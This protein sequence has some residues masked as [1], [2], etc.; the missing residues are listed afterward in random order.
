MIKIRLS[1]ITWTATFL[2]VISGMSLSDAALAGLITFGSNTNQFTMEFVTIGNPGNADDTTGAPNPAGSVAY[3]YQMGKFEVSENMITKYNANFGTANNLIITKDTR[4]VN[5][6]ATSITWNEAARFVNWLNTSTGGVAAYKFTNSDVNGQISLWTPADTLDYD[7]TNR[8]RS[9]RANYVLPS[10]N[11]W[12]K[13][14]FYNPGTGTY[15]DYATGSNT[16]PTAV[17][18]G[19][20]SGTAVFGGQVGPANITLAGGLSPY[21]IMGLSGNVYE[22]NETTYN[23]QNASVSGERWTR[24]GFYGGSTAPLSSLGDSSAG[25]PTSQAFYLGFRV[26]S[27]SSSTAAVPEPSSFVLLATAM[28]I[29]GFVHRRRIKQ[30]DCLPVRSA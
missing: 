18:S 14:A 17:A 27:L 7:A 1:F 4:G 30:R 13:A 11:E 8:F 25:V 12:Y 9:L 10:I 21:G 15:F 28:G 5:K 29:V 3:T 23:L 20:A 24:G 19:T 2:A 22:W 26:A 6:P 16:A